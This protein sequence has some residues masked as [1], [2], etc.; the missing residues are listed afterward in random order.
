M[1]W[2][3]QRAME[4]ITGEIELV[5]AKKTRLQPHLIATL[6][7]TGERPALLMQRALTEN[8]NRNNRL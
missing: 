8:L 3:A 6:E 7:L 5:P 2:R 1:V 4:S